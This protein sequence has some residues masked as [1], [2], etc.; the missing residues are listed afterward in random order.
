MDVFAA[1]LLIFAALFLGA[2]LA[3]GIIALIQI[4]NGRRDRMQM[5]RHLQ[6]TGIAGSGSYQP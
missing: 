2:V 6:Q 3:G 5:K 4:R 1:S